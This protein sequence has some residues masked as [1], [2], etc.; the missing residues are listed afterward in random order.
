MGYNTY[1]QSRTQDLVDSG[2]DVYHMVY[3]QRKCAEPG[4]Q[5]LHDRK[6]EK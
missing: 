3:P 2:V 1:F 4:M 5:A 6:V